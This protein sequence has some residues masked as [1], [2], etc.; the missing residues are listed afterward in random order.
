MTKASRVRAY[1][2]SIWIFLI[3]L[4]FVFNYTSAV[5]EQ[6]AAALEVAKGF[7]HH[8][9]L[10]RLWNSKHGGPYVPVTEK[11]Q[12]NPYLKV[13][14]RDIK[15]SDDFML[16]KINPAFMTRQ[17]SEIAQEKGGVQ[18]HVT[19]LDPIRHQNAPTKL[20]EQFLMEFRRGV[21]EK[22][23][24]IKD[25]DKTSYFYMA[26]LATDKSCLPCHQEL[27]ENHDT[28]RGGISVTT[29]FVVKVPVF[30]LAIAHILI[31]LVGVIAILFTSRKLLDAYKTI[32]EQAYFDS[33][34]GVANRRSFSETLV[35]EYRRSHRDKQPLSIIM[36]DIDN[37]KAYNDTYGHGC[38]DEC[39]E[40]VAK[41]IGASLT[42]AGDLC[43]R[44]GGE[45]FVLL[46]ANTTVEGASHVAER[47]RRNVEQMN[48]A[49]EKS[50]PFGVVT[51]SVGVA[52]SDYN[53]EGSQEELVG[54]ADAALYEAK[55]NGRNNVQ[56][57][58]SSICSMGKEKPC[59]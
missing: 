35:K 50:L 3:S 45:E 24:F 20:E 52:T 57:Y 55:N 14:N 13:P 28:M 17:I 59:E 42:R 46:L 11:T 41:N 12:P 38:G 18:F 27:I 32:Q 21:K 15:V 25:G 56:F 47:V 26:P 54:K 6:E 5:R 49:H 29:P 4:S 2:I 58:N 30:S 8:I 23:T 16:T 36:C 34:T 10:T 53:E 43:A 1:I 51:V 39:L 9:S 22:G 40:K 37:F 33:L 44:Y 48:I 31:A 19:S 7:F